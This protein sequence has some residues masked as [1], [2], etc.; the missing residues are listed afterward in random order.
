MSLKEQ[1]SA[2]L[3]V[4]MK[5]RDQTRVD[6]LRS[7]LS[8]LTYKRT[9]MGVDLTDEEELAVL[10]Q[11]VKERNESIA[12]YKKGVRPELAEKEA[13]ERDILMQ[14]LPVQKFEPEIRV[15]VEESLSPPADG[16]MNETHRLTEREL[17]KIAQSIL[18]GQVNAL[19][20]SM[21]MSNFAAELGFEAYPELLLFVGVASECDRFAF[22]AVRK[23]WAAS[24]LAERDIEM[25][26]TETHFRPLI[27]EACRK[28]LE[29]TFPLL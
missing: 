18:D 14:Y 12:E 13:H 20:G 19:E 2:H 10:H 4:A 26:R 24:L 5:E 8:A 3:K 1:I 6:T 23:L 15:I 11:Q 21:Q 22:G 29:R 25:A 9:E 27:E 16:R 7:V 28:L 17:L